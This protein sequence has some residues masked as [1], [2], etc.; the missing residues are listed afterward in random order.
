MDLL[1]LTEAF[2]AAK[3]HTFSLNTCRAY[4]SDLMACLHD[5][6]SY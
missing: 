6:R 1:E 5:S 2:L 3:Q 4:R